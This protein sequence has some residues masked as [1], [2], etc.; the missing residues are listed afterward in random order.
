ML[1]TV[2]QLTKKKRQKKIR[3]DKVKA[4]KN[5]PQRIA[6]VYKIAIMTPRKPTQL[7]G[8]LLKLELE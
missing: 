7:K 8:L 2:G 1:P 4:L 5:S 3:R 6:I